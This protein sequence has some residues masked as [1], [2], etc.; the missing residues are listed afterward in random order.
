MH[1]SPTSRRSL[2]QTKAHAFSFIEIDGP[3]LSLRRFAGKPMLIVNTAS[4]CAFTNQYGALQ[5]LWDRYRDRGLVV[6]AVPSND[7]GAQEPGSNSAIHEFC[8]SRFGVAF[9]I[10]KKE[11][12]IGEQ[13]HP[14]YRWI[15]A[16]VGEGAS[17]QWNFHKYLID[18]A[19]NIAGL[20]PP[21]TN[22]LDFDVVTAIKALLPGK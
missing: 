13:A 18:G 20:W 2:T 19:G 10:T 22:P 5:E 1:I 7:F 14:F 11:I 3:D 21:E 6:I 17:P 8:Q 16:E 12:V 4:E 15:A 9:P